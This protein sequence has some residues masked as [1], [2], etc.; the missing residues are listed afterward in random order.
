[1]ADCGQS[2]WKKKAESW[3]SMGKQWKTKVTHLSR[4]LE[5]PKY[6]TKDFEINLVTNSEPPK[7]FK[8]EKQQPLSN[9]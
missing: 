7:V 4:I 5:G 3:E 6:H 1:M 9:L 2:K 8:G